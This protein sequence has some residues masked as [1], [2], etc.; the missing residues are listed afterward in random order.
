MARKPTDY[1]QVKVRMREALRR[2]LEKAAEKKKISANAETIERIERTFVL[3]ER[4]RRVEE[5]LENADATLQRLLQEQA[6][7]E[8]RENAVYQAVFADSLVLKTLVGGEENAGLL[9]L[10]ILGLGNN[11]KWAATPESRKDFA[12][13]VHH[14]IISVDLDQKGDKE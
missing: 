10:M 4:V 6:A 2:Q 1:V 9:R 14:F 5:S 12:D 8:A 7:E 3:D 11:P 13:K